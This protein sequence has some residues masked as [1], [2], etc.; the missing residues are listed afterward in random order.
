MPFR[1]VCFLVFLLF[2]ETANSQAQLV[3]LCRGFICYSFLLGIINERVTRVLQNR[4]TNTDIFT[5]F[6]Y[7]QKSTLF[8]AKLEF[9]KT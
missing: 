5:Y 4:F 3:L 2:F 1:H 8:T 7:F 6:E 9:W